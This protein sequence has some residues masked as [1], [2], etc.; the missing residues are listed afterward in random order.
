MSIPSFLMMYVNAWSI[1]P[2]LQPSLPSNNVK[3]ALHNYCV[4]ACMVCTC[5]CVF[6]MDIVTLAS[7]IIRY[8]FS[9]Q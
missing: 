5:A 7:V 6:V 4:C 1:K 8:R 9:G 3:M 2:P